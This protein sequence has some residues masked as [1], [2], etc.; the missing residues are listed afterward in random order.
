M[1]IIRKPQLQQSVG[2]GSDCS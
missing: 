1:K 2:F